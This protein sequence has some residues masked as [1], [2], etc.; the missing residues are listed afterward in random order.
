MKKLFRRGGAGVLAVV[1]ACVMAI[2]S[3]SP[4]EIYADDENG[5]YDTTAPVID[6][7]NVEGVEESYTQ[8]DSLTFKVHVYDE[9]GSGLNTIELGFSGSNVDDATQEDSEWI[10]YYVSSE[11]IGDDTYLLDQKTGYYTLTVP[12]NRFK[13]G[14]KYSLTQI[15]ASDTAGNSVYADS[16]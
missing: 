2:T 5:H 3:Y 7:V 8:N 13:P 1:L 11:N 10:N 6:D 15:M 16:A 14:Y 12:M 9:G 4:L